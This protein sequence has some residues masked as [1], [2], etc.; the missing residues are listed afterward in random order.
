MI[1]GLKRYGAY[2]KVEDGVLYSAA[3]LPNDTPD[4]GEDGEI[5][6]IEVTSPDSHYFLGEINKIFETN[7]KMVQFAGR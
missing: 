2:Y 7:Y 1:V 3:M 4:L 5:N 6:W